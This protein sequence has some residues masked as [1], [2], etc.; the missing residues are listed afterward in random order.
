MNLKPRLIKKRVWAGSLF[1]A[2]DPAFPF[3]RRRDFFMRWTSS[4][5]PLLI[6]SG[7]Y[8]MYSEADKAL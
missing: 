8:D 3:L 1:R 2:Y 4:Y 7:D 5:A 6:R